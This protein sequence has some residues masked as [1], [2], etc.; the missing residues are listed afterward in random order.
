MEVSAKDVMAL[1]KK[2]G[3]GMMD[4]KKALIEAQGDMEKAADM[5]REKG[6]A[7]AQKR[8]ERET[9]QGYIAVYVHPGAKLAAMVEVDCETDFVSRN[10]DF[11]AFTKNIAMHIAAANPLAVSSEE[12]DQDIVEKEREI[13][14][15]QALNEGKNPEFVDKII[16]GRLKKFYAESCLLN[17]MYIRDEKGKTT[18]QDLLNELIGKIGENIVIKKFSRFQIGS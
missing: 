4:C 14:K 15:A 10:E 16:D 5:L 6:I 11:Q 1:R 13:Y 7:S 3:V 17:Q 8:A 9:N 18:I 2:T 12:L